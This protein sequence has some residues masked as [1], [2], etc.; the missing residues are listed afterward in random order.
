MIVLVL[1]ACPA[2]L[3]GSVTRW[4]L[5]ISPGVFVGHASARVRDELWNQV[6]D[7]LKDGK[8]IM[9][10]S[11]QNEQRLDFRTFRHDWE[12]VD[13]D[14]IRLMR[15]PSSSALTQQRVRRGWSKASQR[16]HARHRSSN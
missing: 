13:L 4:L 2:G 12:P 11:A 15:R 14:G 5:E 10:C 16:A 3:R 9:V 6:L 7:L 8:A 1:T